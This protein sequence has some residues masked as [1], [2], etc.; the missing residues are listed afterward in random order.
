MPVAIVADSTSYLPSEVVDAEGIHLVSLYLNRDGRQERELDITDYPRFYD[1]LRTA[2]QLPTTSQPSI[3]DFLAVMEPLL[4]DGHDVLC[5]TLS[6][7]ISGTN[8][9][10]EQA[11]ADAGPRYGQ[12]RIHVYDS[13]SAC[14]AMG[15]MA[16][17]AARASARGGDLEACTAAADGV[18]STLKSWFAVDTLEYLRRGGRIGSAQAWLGGALKV[19]PILTID[20]VITPIERVR[21]SSRAFARLLEYA[22]GLHEDGADAWIVQHIQAG[23]QATALTDACREVFGSEPVFIGEIGPVIGS[24]VGPGLLGVGGLPGR[25]LG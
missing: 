10:A 19:K 12:R 4:A 24:H 5:I 23:E 3:G 13:H 25:L 9:A 21:T 2:P 14:G 16:I 17:A 20:D 7:A 18:R 8:Q 6:G 22:K 11:A 1:E 15:A